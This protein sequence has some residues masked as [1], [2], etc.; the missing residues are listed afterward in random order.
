MGTGENVPE[1]DKASITYQGSTL[2]LTPEWLEYSL[3]ESR[4]KLGVECIDV[5]LL[6]QPELFLL[7]ARDRNARYRDILDQ[8]IETLLIKAFTQLEEEYRKGHIQYY[9]VV[10]ATLGHPGDSIEH[11]SPALILRAAQKA[12]GKDHRCRVLQGP[13]NF[14]EPGLLDWQNASTKEEDPIS[15]AEYLSQKSVTLLT[16]RPLN[17][18][19][20]SK[21]HRFEPVPPTAPSEDFETALEDLKEVEATLRDSFNLPFDSAR[22]KSLSRIYF[23]SQMN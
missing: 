11:L 9:G 17:A 8:E 7:D 2:C 4:H 5:V 22:R 18:S 10:S 20:G 15:V 3:S 19:Q 16:H 6:T 21:L 1:Y 13:L 12:G 23:I 14:L